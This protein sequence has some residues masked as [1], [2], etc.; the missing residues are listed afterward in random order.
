MQVSANLSGRNYDQFHWR[1]IHCNCVFN[2]NTIANYIRDATDTQ[3]NSW[4][5][6]DR[7]Y[8]VT[9]CNIFLTEI[10]TSLK[11]M[12]DN[13]TTWITNECELRPLSNLDRLLACKFLPLLVAG[14][15]HFPLFLMTKNVVSRSSALEPVGAFVRIRYWCIEVESKSNSETW[16]K[17]SCNLIS[18]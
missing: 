16:I 1:E 2:K 13:Y 3:W 11:K 5:R 14:L 9:N 10:S 17:A 12:T 8:H 15:W 6:W 7:G 4:H 18:C